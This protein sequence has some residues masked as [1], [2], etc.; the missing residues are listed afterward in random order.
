MEHNAVI[1][2]HWN[3]NFISDF[4]EM[5]T[6]IVDLEIFVHV[7]FFTVVDSSSNEGAN[8]LV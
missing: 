5:Q 8:R 1:L 3:L 4:F 6:L 2:K 7:N